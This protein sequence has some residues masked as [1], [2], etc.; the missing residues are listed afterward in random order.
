MYLTYDEYKRFGGALDNAAFD[1]YGY[2]AECEIRAHTH[3]RI[4]NPSE[5]VKRCA[6]RLS[7]LAAQADIK[8]EKVS[9]FSHDGLSQTFAAPTAAEF[10]QKAEDIIYKYLGSECAEDGTPL[11]YLGV[12]R[13]D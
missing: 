7:D 5:A 1:V 10:S 8:P 12:E 13:Y 6:A 9:S 4:T 2:E 11:L 3:G